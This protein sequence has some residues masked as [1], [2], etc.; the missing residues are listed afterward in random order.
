M[1]QQKCDVGNPYLEIN[2]IFVVQ[3]TCISVFFD[4]FPYVYQVRYHEVSGQSGNF[5]VGSLR[6][7]I[8]LSLFFHDTS[9]LFT[10]KFVNTPYMWFCIS[11]KITP[12]SHI[13]IKFNV[14]PPSS[15]LQFS[16]FSQRYFNILS[17]FQNF[18]SIS[19]SIQLSVTKNNH[20]DEISGAIKHKKNLLISVP[21]A[22]GTRH[23]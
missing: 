7:L 3:N 5:A 10:R 6:S 4:Y 14:L 20:N 2:A 23:T 17:S 15:Q 19:F 18:K 11:N 22:N 16:I 8:F 1:L 9:V 21:I 12:Y 13:N